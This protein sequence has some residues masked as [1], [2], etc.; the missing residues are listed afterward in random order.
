MPISGD[1]PTGNVLHVDGIPMSDD[2]VQIFS[3]HA[4]STRGYMR[5]FNVYKSLMRNYCLPMNRYNCL[6]ES[7]EE[8]INLYRMLVAFNLEDS[9]VKNELSPEFVMNVD[10]LRA[11]RCLNNYLDYQSELLARYPS[12]TRGHAIYADLAV[13]SRHYLYLFP[14]TNFTTMSRLLRNACWVRAK[15]WENP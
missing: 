14:S 9:A 5:D 7:L 15:D 1:I 8:R 3:R 11:P 4:V 10:F 6:L 2:L 13:D 12:V